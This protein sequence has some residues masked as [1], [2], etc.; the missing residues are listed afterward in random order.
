MCQLPTLQKVPKNVRG[1]LGDKRAI[2]QQ[3][4]LEL[5]LFGDAANLLI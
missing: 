5:V 2:A 3:E 4:F 1:M